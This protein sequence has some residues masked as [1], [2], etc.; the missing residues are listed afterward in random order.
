MGRNTSRN[1]SARRRN[2]KN[3]KKL[4]QRAKQQAKAK[5]SK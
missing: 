5:K 3:R 2:Q 1:L 4:S